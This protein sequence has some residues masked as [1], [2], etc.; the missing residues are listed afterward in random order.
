MGTSSRK[1]F[2][3]EK[4]SLKT[5]DGDSSPNVSPC[6]PAKPMNEQKDSEA[7]CH[8]PAFNELLAPGA[9]YGS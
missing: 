5:G 8:E 2:T 6:S 7:S 1:G 4:A 9:Q 3:S